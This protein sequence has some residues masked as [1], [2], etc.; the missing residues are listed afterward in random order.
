MK[1]VIIEREGETIIKEIIK[2]E[3]IIKEIPVE[4][5]V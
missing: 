4:V 3:E 1:E 2:K 5:E